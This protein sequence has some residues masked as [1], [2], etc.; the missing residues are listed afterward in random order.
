MNKQKQILIIGAIFIAVIS[1]L[2]FNIRSE[3]KKEYNITL[4]EIDGISRIAYIQKLDI[5]IKNIRGINQ[6]S[7]SQA[8]ALKRTLFISEDTILDS[9]KE[10]KDKNIENEYISFLNIK[11][12]ISK[13]KLFKKYTSLL[14]L[15]ERKRVDIADSSHLLYEADREIYF[16][17]TTAILNIP[18]TIENIGIIRGIGVS[19]LRNSDNNNEDFILKNN[20]YMFLE[21]IVNI[22]F[23][24]SKLSPSDSSQLNILL[25]SIMTDFYDINTIVENLANETSSLTPT[26]YFLQTSK[27]LNNINNV[28]SI[29]KNIL[30]KKLED[31]K[32]RLDKKLFFGNLLYILLLTSVLLT[33]Y[34]NH[35]NNA[36][37]DEEL[38]KKRNQDIFISN[39]QDD[40]TKEETLKQIC[41]SSLKHIIDQFK[42]I[43][44]SLY[45]YNEYNEKLYLGATYAIRYSSL[46]HTLDIHENIISENIAEKKINIKEIF[47]D[48]SLGNVTTT[49]KKLVTIPI[50]EF[51]TSIG[52]MQLLFDD[53]FKDVDIDFLTKIVSLMATYINK[54]LHDDESHRYL[55]L[56]DKN[57]LISK[58][59]LDGNITQV[60]EELCN[61]SK[62]TK[63]ELLGHNHRTFK[64]EDT[65]QEIFEDMWNTI[66]QGITW[67][68]ELKNRTKDGGFYWVDSVI[69]PDKDINGNTIGYT[70]I[71]TNIT[72]KKKIEE[73]AI[74]DGLTSLYNRRHF[75]NIFVQQ[76]EII[77][78]TKGMLAFLLMD[79]DHFKQYNDTYGHQDGDTTLKLVA[80]ALKKTLKRPDDYT[81]RLGGE[82]FGLLYHITN[83]DDGISIADLA[84][85]NIENLKIEH[86][87]NSAS[88]YVT[89]SS[90][91]YI[92]KADDT[93][94]DDEIYKMS[95]EALYVAKQSGRNQVAIAKS[96]TNV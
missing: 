71:R 32:D 78:R 58:T 85:Q 87:G 73:I 92:I 40:Y 82:E 90:G 77:K 64:H 17:I 61:L 2:F 50:M 37:K 76:M 79:I 81:F 15:L 41:N 65:P 44:G 74:T 70:A 28:F 66:T 59:D 22:K 11:D 57:V 13:E 63:D 4:N 43:N 75:D 96:S 18:K 80:T 51:E 46:E 10:L 54:A 36:K 72:D 91:L 30:T 31:R 68:G 62:Y 89:I 3:Y 48:I 69:S 24:I 6:L 14:K 49:T 39:L 55:K 34:I 93:R 9:I 56:I 26:E 86:S 7:I 23:I 53:K 16:L 35:R 20:I 33:I 60:S 29:S 5:L 84:R 19:I 52:T 12:N 27:L 1:I 88:Q 94:S 45:L 67:R 8:K 47:Q 42:A 21:N 25:E 83:E 95:D 38:Q